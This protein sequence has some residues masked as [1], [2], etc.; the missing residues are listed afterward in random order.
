MESGGNGC[1]SGA[2][3]NPVVGPPTLG[4]GE[5]AL[6]TGQA[7]G[8]LREE[9]AGRERRW[10]GQR[11]A[12]WTRGTYVDAQQHR[13]PEAHVIGSTVLTPLWDSGPRLPAAWGPR[14]GTR[15]CT[16]DHQGIT[17]PW[18]HPIEIHLQ[19]TS[20]KSTSFLRADAGR[21]CLGPALLVCLGLV[22]PEPPC[23]TGLRTTHL[24]GKSQK[25]SAS[26]CVLKFSQTMCPD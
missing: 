1:P 7:D 21:M 9:E 14:Q 2:R 19:N 18:P 24:F 4:T 5:K 3:L 6:G 22:P 11:R 13:G 17:V 25:T 15:S 8:A 12:G 20:V 10:P 23:L 26:I 16:H